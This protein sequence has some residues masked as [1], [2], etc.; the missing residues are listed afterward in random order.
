[1]PIVGT[2]HNVES[3][4]LRRRAEQMKSR[5]SSA[6]VRHQAD[7]I[8]RIEKSLAPRC[9][10]NVTTSEIDAERLSPLPRAQAR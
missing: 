6:Y 3:Q 8:E 2:H 1:V 7:L 5:I 9:A 10:L 4:L